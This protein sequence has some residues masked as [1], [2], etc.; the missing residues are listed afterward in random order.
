MKMTSEFKVGLF[1]TAALLVLMFSIL[2]VSNFRFTPGGYVVSA[3]FAFLGD[4]KVNAA[5]EYAG[6]I[7]VGEVKNIRYANNKA[8]VDLLI[9][10]KNFKLRQDSLVALYSTGLLGS[11]YVEIGAD[12]GEGPELQSGET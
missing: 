1:T 6:G 3:T 2:F 9:T 5:V 7:R 10:E 11:R 4:L 8:L 12:L